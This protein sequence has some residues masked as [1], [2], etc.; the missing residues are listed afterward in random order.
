MV[1]DVDVW[2]TIRIILAILGL[3]A[4]IVGARDIAAALRKRR[5]IKE[6]ERRE[7]QRAAERASHERT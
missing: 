5:Q 4:V 3:A 1:D 2:M 6:H 7:L